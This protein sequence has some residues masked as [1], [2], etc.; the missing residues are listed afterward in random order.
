[1]EWS[2]ALWNRFILPA[3]TNR[4]SYDIAINEPISKSYGCAHERANHYYPNGLAHDF[5]YHWPDANANAFPNGQ[6][7][8]NRTNEPT[9][10]LTNDWSD[11]IS[12]QRAFQCTD[13]NANIRTFK[14]SNH[15][16]PILPTYHLSY[17][18]PNT[19]PNTKPK[20]LTNR[21]AVCSSN[22]LSATYDCLLST[23]PS[24]LCNNNP[25]RL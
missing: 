4:E 24:L 13:A 19:I 12:N 25:N 3:S 20:L 11:S 6:P 14:G 18:R 9:N 1:M 5:A 10:Y 23:I 21:Q 22:T 17:F 8:Y 2:P 7:N 15:L 16:E